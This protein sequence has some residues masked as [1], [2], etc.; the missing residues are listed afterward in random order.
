MAILVALACVVPAAAQMNPASIGL[1]LVMSSA[2]N[3]QA[4]HHAA[5]RGGRIGRGGAREG[6]ASGRRAVPAPARPVVAPSALHYHVDPA[7]QQRDLDAFVAQ[8][9][10]SDPTSGAEL[11]R[12][13]REQHVY[14]ALST[15]MQRFGM[16]HANLA[17]CM[18]IYLSVAWQA[19]HGTNADPTPAQLA[20]LR[21]QVTRAMLTVPTLGRLSDE[22]KQGLADFTLLQA[23]LTDGMGGRAQSDPASR[24]GVRDGVAQA[25]RQV[26]SFDILAVRYTEDGFVPD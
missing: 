22:M 14:D 12:Q 17:D 1:G 5:R 8:V 16:D 24:Q 23:A 15:G 19:V 6:R 25:V 9:S 4:G 7:A 10:K 13:F 20:G 2:I 11:G 18:T 21:A 3:A 26:Y